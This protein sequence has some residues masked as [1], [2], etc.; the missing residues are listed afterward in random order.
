MA[1]LELT[2]T[3][4]ATACAL[5]VP[6]VFLLLRRQ[7]L[8][9]DA[10]GHVVLPGIAAGALLAGSVRSPWVVL[11]A[12]ASG[13]LA[14]TIVE[15]LERQRLVRSD[16]A[17]GLVYPALFAVGVILIARAPR[18]LHLDADAV[19]LGELHLAPL[20]RLTWGGIDVPW[21]LAVMSVLFVVNLAFV[22]LAYK[23][24]AITTFDPD[25]ARGQGVPPGPIHYALMTLVALTIVAAFDAAGPVLV[26]AFL[27]APAATAHLL[28]NRLNWLL[29]FAVAVA[30]LGA[31]LGV[32]LAMRY[33]LNMSGA[34]AGM[35]GVLF[36]AAVLFAPRYGLVAQEVRRWRLRKEFERG[37]LAVHL[38]HHEGTESAEEECR[39]DR[40]GEHLA[41][42][43][44]K[45]TRVL[46]SAVR[47]GLVTADGALVRLTGSGRDLAR[48]L[49]G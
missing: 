31:T 40:L 34:V 27:A 42:P 35:A 7:T 33:N 26:V 19:L 2:L 20:R 43:E 46:Q 11:G 17:L 18:G 28:T 1:P 15:W 39:A 12:T 37:L 44:P 45:V 23:E 30:G 29:I 25:H 3:A 38:A 21:S 36:A 41:W 9:G 14:V 49:V 32:E 8:L 5:A 22:L 24:L 13:V 10:L 16:A 4:V 48:R 47:A 6:G